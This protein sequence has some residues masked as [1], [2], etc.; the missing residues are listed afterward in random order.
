MPLYRV[1]G[2]PRPFRDT[3]P[4]L[5][6]VMVA[7]REP[8]ADGLNVTLIVQLTPAARLAPHVPPA[9]P[10]GRANSVVE[11]AKLIGCDVVPVLFTVT[12]FEADVVPTFWETKVNA[13]GDTFID[14]TAPVPFSVKLPTPVAVKVAVR[15]PAA[16]GVN[17]T[18]IVQLAPAATLP[19]QV[20]PAAPVGLVNSVVEKAMLT[21]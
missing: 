5:V 16:A 15:A 20:P 12:T 4:A 17:V 18:L 13:A 3:P 21:G 2:V 9:V 1:H 19:P 6:T 10:E 14:G 11:K 8:E 7:V